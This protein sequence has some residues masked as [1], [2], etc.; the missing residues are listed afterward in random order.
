MP[1]EPGDLGPE[2]HAR[3]IAQY[4]SEV[5]LRDAQGDALRCFL[6]ANLETPVA[7]DEV[8]FRSG[9]G[10]GVVV[11]TLP[12]SN[13]LRRPDRFGKQRVVA[14]NID[15]VVIVLAALPQPHSSLVDRYLVACEDLGAEALILLN[16]CDLLEDPELQSQ[17]S[18]VLEP[19]GPLAYPVLRGSAREAVPGEL[20]AAL[21][22]HTSI[23]VGQSGVGKTTLINAL[24]PEAGQRVGELSEER[25]KGRHTTTTT[26][27]FELTCGGALIDSPGIREFGLWHLE[28]DAIERGFREIHAAAAH[29]RFRDCRHAGEP[30]C[31]VAEALEKGEIHPARWDSYQ[32]ILAEAGS[33]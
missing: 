15:R 30:G 10:G 24:L 28:R 22:G 7:G 23:L 4:G 16:K 14:A 9:S 18:A 19:Y 8:V 11:A 1:D 13:E 25:S 32:R 2:Q 29:C 21:R 27:L 6:R 17:V 12:R 3:V 20:A 26:R 33:E 5:D 31:A